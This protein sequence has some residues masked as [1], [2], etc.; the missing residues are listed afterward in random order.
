MRPPSPAAG[1][2][3]TRSRR[4]RAEL[5]AWGVLV[6]LALALRL[7]DLGARPF[8]HDESQ[9]AYFSWVFQS[10]GDYEYDPLL[11]GPLRF[12]LTA[13][14]YT[15]FGDSDF[16]ARL[17]PALMGT[18]MV[19]MLYPLRAQL[20]RIAAFAAAAL[21]AVGPSYL[22]FSRFAREDIYIAAITLAMLVVT[23]RFFDAPRRWHPAA[24][25][26]LLAASFA[27]K[28]TTFITIFVAGSFF[29]VAIFVQARRAGG[30]REAPVVRTL[31]GVGWE[32]HAWGVVAFLAVYTITFTTFL[33]HPSGIYGLWTGLDYWL[34]QHG[35]GRGGES[36]VFYSVVLFAHEWPVL[37][38]GVV[39]AVLAFRRPTLLRLFLVWAFVLSL[40]VYSWAGEKFAWLILHPLL[41]LTLL[42]GVGLQELWASRHSLPG[43]LALGATALA[44]A[45]TV[46]ASALVNA[47][48]P[49]DPREFLVS[50]QSSTDVADEARRI[51]ALD[52]R[53]DGKLKILVDSR[54]GRD[55][56]V[57]LVL[58]RPRRRLPGP[59]DRGRA[60]G[61]QRRDRAH[62]ELQ[63]PPPADADRLRRARDPLPRLVGA[64]L[65][66]G[67]LPRRLVALVQRARA[68]EPDRRDAGVGLRA[69]GRLGRAAL[70]EVPD[71]GAVAIEHLA[72]EAVPLGDPAVAVVG[73]LDRA[74][75]HVANAVPREPRPRRLGRRGRVHRAHVVG[76][77]ARVVLPLEL[78]AGPADHGRAA[79]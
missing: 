16:T 11:H 6:A 15:L 70:A 43:K 66:Q 23:F 2:R 63:P 71:R 17:A 14:V 41:P 13:A 67:A 19:A 5:I 46:W 30:L 75:D 49:A 33:T 76:A 68:V 10:D 47:V 3:A 59:L 37:L 34:G 18:S 61:R 53:R 36:P 22:Y 26:A 21:L 12:Y 31:L 79:R 55:V 39:G 60:A 28:E 56:P 72:A 24:F 58:P 20:G 64:R 57:G 29:L 44:L 73:A 1:G 9:D 62:P 78:V 38:L 54:R 52:K 25:G 77:A 8:H 50:T 45:Y 42:A 40:I 65:R 48:H 27:T 4:P 51:V 35:V 32:P 7:Y 74:D 69:A